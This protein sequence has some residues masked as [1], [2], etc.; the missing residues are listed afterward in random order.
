MLTQAWSLNPHRGV[1]TR[2]ER[3][4][5]VCGASL[6]VWGNLSPFYYY[7]PTYAIGRGS[8][9]LKGKS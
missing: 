7:Y 8:A 5:R 3:I 6:P 2:Q 4:A 9:L 1:G